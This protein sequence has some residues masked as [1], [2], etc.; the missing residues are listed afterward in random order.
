M[1]DAE[2]PESERV[3]RY[4][5]EIRELQTG[6]VRKR[7]LT[8]VAKILLTQRKNEAPR[9]PEEVLHLQDG[10]ETI[11]AKNFE[12]LKT[13]LRQRFPDSEYERTLHSERDHDGERR[14]ADALKG[15]IELLAEVAVREFLEEEARART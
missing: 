5:V 8:A 12:D 11:E 3:F 2:A 7:P 14:R 10:A 9:P 4:W 6:V 13:Q 15:L 1:S